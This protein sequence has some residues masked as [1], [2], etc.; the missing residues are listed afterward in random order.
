M[1]LGLRRTPG[2]DRSEE[3][4]VT[5]LPDAERFDL[6]FGTI[7]AT[8]DGTATSN[9]EI[10]TRPPASEP[11]ARLHERLQR[12]AGL[13]WMLVGDSLEPGT[14]P[15][16]DWRSFGGR[17][18]EYVRTGLGRRRDVVIVNTAPAQLL[19]EVAAEFETQSLPVQPGVVMFCVGPREALAGITGLDSFE[20]R[21]AGLVTQVQDRGAT[22]ILCTP[23]L[24]PTGN[25]T[26][27]AVQCIYAEAVRATAAEYDVPLVDHWLAWESA[28]Q[29]GQAASDWLL[30]DSIAPG[31]RGHAEL[32]ER[33]ADDLQL[34]RLAPIAPEAG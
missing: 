4:T 23:P 3:P 34:A 29:R 33:L 2:S 27:T 5:A 26:A 17:F 32:A 15:A 14:G 6:G 16:R 24:I 11:L 30:P 12:S 21:L 25:S 1:V 13:V 19:A 10:S 31:P 28:V 20:R 8:A 22:P 9:Q 7:P 18:T